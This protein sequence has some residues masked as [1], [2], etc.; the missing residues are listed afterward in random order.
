MSSWSKPGRVLRAAG[1]GDEVF[2]FAEPARPA[3]PIPGP[4]ARAEDLVAS[5]E[6][7]A[8]RLLAEARAE[9][10]AI[11]E[12]A[13]SSAAQVRDAAYQ[14]GYQKGHQE[15]YAAGHDAARAELDQCLELVRRAAADGKVIRDSIVEEAGAVMARAVSLATRRIVGEYYETDPERTTAAI[16]DALRAA[17]GQQIVAIRVNPALEEAVRARLV[18]VAAYVRPDDAVKIGG[19]YIDLQHGTLDATLDTRLSLLDAALSQAAGGEVAA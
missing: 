16:A 6:Q 19:C 3:F 13:R 11:L 5:A 9:A 10:A 7:E 12:E 17:S 1:A 14:E 15:G 8:A 4:I 2:V 18:E